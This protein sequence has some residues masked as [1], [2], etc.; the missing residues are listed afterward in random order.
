MC[1]SNQLGRVCISSIRRCMLGYVHYIHVDSLARLMLHILAFDMFRDVLVLLF[2]SILYTSYYPFVQLALHSQLGK[3]HMGGLF[4]CKS[5]SIFFVI[6]FPHD[7]TC[8]CFI[9][10]ISWVVLCIGYKHNANT[11]SN[12]SR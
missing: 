10:G 11:N 9:G 5:K 12:K 1:L 4:F 3:I 7:H 2:P 6:S 8:T